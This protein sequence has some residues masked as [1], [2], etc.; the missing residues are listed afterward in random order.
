M[1]ARSSSVVKFMIATA[2][3]FSWLMAIEEISSTIANH[4][5]G[6]SLLDLLLITFWNPL[7]TWLPGLFH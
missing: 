4:L 5:L 6:I 7:T 3:T 1:A 2:S